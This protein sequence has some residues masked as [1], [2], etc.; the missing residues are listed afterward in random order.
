MYC[1]YFAQF[2]A[3]M[4]H[5]PSARA[6]WRC[7]H[8]T[9]VD[10]GWTAC[11]L[12]PA[13]LPAWFYTAFP[14]PYHHLTDCCRPADVSFTGTALHTVAVTTFAV[15]R[16][17]YRCGLLPRRV[18]PGARLHRTFYTLP[19]RHYL[20]VPAFGRATPVTRARLSLPTACAAARALSTYLR[21][22]TALRAVFFY[23]HLPSGPSHFWD[24]T[25]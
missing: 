13:G 10:R 9:L 7:R 15:S 8:V 20:V 24:H 1:I 16:I 22:H 11:H 18:G 21:L 25:L 3:C 19:V 12:V 5:L 17:Y 4:R 23:H 2:R 6:A 14:R